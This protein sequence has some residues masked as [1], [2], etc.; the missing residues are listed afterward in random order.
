MWIPDKVIPSPRWMLAVPLLRSV[1]GAFSEQ[2]T[3]AQETGSQKSDQVS[4]TDPD[5]TAGSYTTD[6]TTRLSLTFRVPRS[7]PCRFPSCWTPTL[8]NTFCFHIALTFFSVV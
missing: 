6:Q 7:V 3:P 4:G 5:P 2:G 8:L 1:A